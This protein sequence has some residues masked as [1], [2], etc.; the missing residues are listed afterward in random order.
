MTESASET[1]A[2][3]PLKP[4]ERRVVGVLV[5]KQKTTPEYYPMTVAAIVSGCNQKS[6]RD[7]QTSYDAD[8]VEETLNSLRAKGAVVIYEG[9]GRVPKW[10]HRL[11][12]WLDLKNKPADLAVLAELLLRGPQTEGEL[13]SRA[14]RMD[15][16]AD[17][18]ALE[19][20]LRNLEERGL[21]VFLTPP[22]QKRGVV[23]SH[24]MYPPEELERVRS[25]QATA[26]AAGGEASFAR[27]ERAE[28]AAADPKI[29]E[30]MAR[31]RGEF[32]EI[33]LALRAAQEDI[34]ALRQELGGL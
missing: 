14:S 28:A 33:K 17:L 20:I 23:V 15:A 6:N 13:R 34:A 4:R 8:E 7:P 2:W 1:R 26:M 9:T 29:A 19:T 32:E 21:V 24:G 11:Y 22:G 30:E 31:L 3:V 25:T 5:E 27:Q 16:I 18:E 10:K 12:D